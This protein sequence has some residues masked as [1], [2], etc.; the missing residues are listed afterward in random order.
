MSPSLNRSRRVMPRPSARTWRRGRRRVVLALQRHAD[1]LGGP[2]DGADRPDG[3]GD[4]AGQQQP[5]GAQHPVVHHGDG[6]AVV[7]DGGQAMVQTTA[8]K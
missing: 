3:P 8:S 1:D 7:G 5:A 4:V 6:A 2:L